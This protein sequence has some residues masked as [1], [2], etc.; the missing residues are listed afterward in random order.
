MASTPGNDSFTTWLWQVMAARKLDRDWTLLARNHYLRTDYTARGDVLQDRAQLGLAW[1]PVDHNRFNALAKI[2]HKLERDA[3]NAAAGDLQSRAWI[4]ST[5][6]DWHPSRPWWLTGRL[7]AK[8]Q[9]D[10]LEQGVQDKFHATMVSGRAVYDI[11][12]RID[13]GLM[14]AVQ[15]GQHG[16]RQHAVGVEAG[17]LL[18]QNLWLSA[19]YNRSGFKG[20]ADLAGYDYTQRGAFIRLRFKFDETLFRGRDP[21][22]NRTLDRVNER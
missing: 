15:A 21:Q 11:T 6:A 8:W 2:E 19:G 1:R 14:A 10:R 20:D 13:L 7:A 4:A 17:Y 16:A 5:H 3:S 18:Q 9:T 22:V 12:E